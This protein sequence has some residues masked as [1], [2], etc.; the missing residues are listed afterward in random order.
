MLL[1]FA[2]I[3]AIGLS[4]DS[5]CRRRISVAIDVSGSISID[6]STGHQRPGPAEIKA[7]LKETMEKY[8]FRDPR[9]CVAIYRFATNASLV[10]DF[11]PISAPATRPT[12][13]A[14]I[15]ELEFEMSHPGYYT[16]WEAGLKKVLDNGVHSD[17]VYLVTDGA[18]TTRLSGCSNNQ[19]QPCP[20][21]ANLNIEAATTVAHQ[22][23]ARGTG[24][25][26][27]G[28]GNAVTDDQLKAISMPCSE[29]FGCIRGWNYFH[30]TSIGRLSAP[31]GRSFTDR[32]LRSPPMTEHEAIERHRI[33]T[34]TENDDLAPP[35]VLEENATAT[36]S[37]TTTTSTAAPDTT[38]TTAASTTTTAAPVTTTTTSAPATTTTTT[39]ATTTTTAAVI[40]TTSVKPLIHV[41]S[42]PTGKYEDVDSDGHIHRQNPPGTV[43]LNTG[44][45][46]LV[47]V[48]SLLGSLTLLVIGYM[49]FNY[50]K[51]GG[52]GG[53]E[54]GQQQQDVNGNMRWNV[55][56]SINGQ[57]LLPQPAYGNPTLLPPPR[58]GLR[59]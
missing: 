6:P 8:L 3:V 59:R 45:V 58:F 14:A 10:Y 42:A 25:V 35:P 34:K 16:N 55:G 7:A 39:A 41:Q 54:K 47:I 12:L 24:V 31:L 1:L 18:P 11:A 5:Q 37:N 57:P 40:A 30:V 22:L 43:S 15:D 38:T 32:F 20:G 52:N 46:I 51:G 33:S 49:L 36:S 48:G 4:T 44:Q 2:I 13:L 19:E 28:M 17:W 27:V 50:C 26:A 56:T 53:G 9:S 21:A 29:K 23:L